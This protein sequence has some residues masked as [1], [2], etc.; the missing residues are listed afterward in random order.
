MNFFTRQGQLIAISIAMLLFNMAS[1]AANPVKLNEHHNTLKVSENTARGFRVTLHFSDFATSDIKTGQGI[2]TRVIIPDYA[3]SGAFG[4]PELPV[5]SELIEIPAGARVL[6]SVISSTFREFSLDDLGISHPLFP[7]QPPIPKTGEPVGF[8]YAKGAYQVDAFMPGNL[9]EVE[10]LGMMRNANIGRLDIFPVQY[11]PLKGKIRIFE[12]LELEIIFEGGD[13]AASAMQKQVYGNHYFD[14]VFNTLINYRQPENASRENFARY[15]IKYVLVSDRMFEAT[16][17]PFIEWKTRKGFTVIEAY[18]DDPAVGNTTTQIKSY[19]QDLYTSATPDDPAPTFILFVGDIAQIPTW[20]GVAAGHVTDLY[21]CEYTGDYFPDVF[22]GRFSAQN[23]A[24]LQPQID[25]TLMYEQYTMP[26]PSYLD[27]VVMVAGMDGAYA[28]THGNGQIN[29]GTINYFNEDNWIFSHTYLYPSSGSNAANIRQNISDGVTFGNYTAHCSPS[30]WGDPSFTTSHIPALQNEG[31]YGLLVGNCCSSSEY[32]LN[33]CFGEALLR[34][35]DKGAVAYIGASNSTYWDEDYY[36]GVGVGQ[37]A[38]NPPPY[39]QTSLGFYDRAFH[40]HGEP[41]AE[42]YTTADQMIYAG[43][44]AVT[45]GKPGSARY[46][47]EA[48]NLL[49]DPSLMVYFSMPPAMPVTYDPLVPL[50]SPDFLI[51]AVPY[52]YAALSFDGELYGAALADSNGMA[53]IDISGI[54]VP[55]TAD[56]VVTA[57]NYQPFEDQVLIA[58][59]EGPY[60]LMNQYILHDSPDTNGL[61]EPGEEVMVD[62]ELKN[63]GNSDAMN[64]TATLQSEDGYINIIWDEKNFGTIAMQDSVMQAEAF[65]FGVFDSIPDQHVVSFQVV[66][67]DDS[68]REVWNSSFQV[69]L[70]APVMNIGS[71]TIVDTAGGNGNGRLD[72]GETVDLVLNCHN[73]GHCNAYDILTVVQSYS[74]YITIHNDST[75]IDTLLWN[76]MQQATFTITLAD[77]IE[78]GTS[79]D[80]LFSMVSEPYSDEAVYYAQVGLLVEDFETGDFEAFNWYHG[81]N[82]P[83]QITTSNVYEGTYSA[84]SGAIGNN[85]ITVLLIDMDVAMNDSI[86]FYRK[87]SCEDDPNGTGYDWLGFYIDN[88]IME[89]WDGE[90]DWERFSFPVTAGQH[91]FKWVYSKDYSVASGMDAAWI[92]FIV[93]PGIAPTVSV[94]ERLAAGGLSMDFHPNPAREQTAVYL[95]LPSH[96][97]VSLT[98]F[99]L[100]GKKIGMP[101]D[102]QPLTEGYHRL[103]IETGYL[104]A[105]IYFGVLKAGNEWVTRKLVITR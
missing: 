98:L 81:G 7:H 70:N 35:V 22:Y 5:K 77:E 50:G 61:I 73:T 39:E 67:H 74:P 83:W 58:N 11:N 44:L 84:R 28:I 43:N 53:V 97:K 25:K 75:T 88:T 64:V 14:A 37:I 34:A 36:F 99:D 92:D 65:S 47:W 48:Y 15:P 68:T 90:L 10:S 16:L 87:V 63:W 30:G 66:I 41:F 19:L 52:A 45:Q 51:Q 13:P 76:D 95:H 33:E 31:K 94:D 103:G 17:Q 86:S 21:Y 8:V 69:L 96:G 26:E 62:M 71:L 3:Y 29:Y 32:Q 49:G 24:Q 38:T 91:T 1:I 4:H 54:T 78:E 27:T 56:V 60:V 104:K 85:Q 42:W 100:A 79:V 6:V 101:V 105:G 20:N 57:Q 80:L 72:P 55:G 23:V 2:F 59:P 102:E 18:T 93:F 9:A 82:Q 12:Q 40:T 46:Y 89:S